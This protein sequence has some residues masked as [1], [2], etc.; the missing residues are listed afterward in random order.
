MI[1]TYGGLETGTRW[2]FFINNAKLQLGVSGGNVVSTQ[3]VADGRWHHAAAVLE[4]PETGPA[5]VR[6]LRLYIDGQPDAGICTNPDLEI[7]TDAFCLV[8]V[9]TILQLS[10]T[11]GSFFNGMIDDVRLYERALSRQEI[12]SLLQ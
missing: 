4:A 7:H 1:L 8:R 6:N 3:T 2:L 11:L 5:K 10:G 9:G 12:Q